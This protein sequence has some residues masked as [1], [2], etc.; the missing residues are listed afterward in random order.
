MYMVGGKTDRPIIDCIDTA[1]R[2]MLENQ[3]WLECQ[4]RMGN[5]SF[6]AAELAFKKS[7][8]EYRR[9]LKEA[10]MVLGDRK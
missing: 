2:K 4:R 7:K 3:R 5:G 10:R 9:V 8:K 1:V 6:D